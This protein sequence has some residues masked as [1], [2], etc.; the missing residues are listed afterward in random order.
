[1]RVTRQQHRRTQAC[2]RP[3]Y[4]HRTLDRRRLALDHGGGVGLAEELRGIGHGFEIIDDGQLVNAQAVADVADGHRPREVV[5][6]DGVGCEE[7]S[8]VDGK[9]PYPEV[10][11]AAL[12]NRY[13]LGVATSRHATEP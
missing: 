12:P 13:S 1:V 10:V 4:Q 3:H 11:V 8:R 9:L 7:R 2:A 6:D 5:V